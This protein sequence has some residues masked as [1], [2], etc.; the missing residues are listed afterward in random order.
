M[1]SFEDLYDKQ[2][3]EIDDIL[4]KKTNIELLV[5]FS[6]AIETATRHNGKLVL[7]WDG[8]QITAHPIENEIISRMRE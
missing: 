7:N 5:M 1:S 6:Q 3:R 2:I 4:K 8:V